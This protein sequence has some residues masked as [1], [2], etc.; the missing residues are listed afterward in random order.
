MD[1]TEAAIPARGPAPA[2]YP[3]TSQCRIDA[4]WGGAGKA[5]IDT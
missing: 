2:Q 1:I 3:C 4:E 5:F